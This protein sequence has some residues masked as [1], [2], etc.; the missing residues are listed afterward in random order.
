MFTP[1]CPEIRKTRN[2]FQLKLEVSLH[3]VKQTEANFPPRAICLRTSLE[4]GE[5]VRLVVPGG[6]RFYQVKLSTLHC[7]TSP[8]GNVQTAKVYLLPSNGVR[9]SNVLVLSVCLSFCSQGM[10]VP[11]Q[12]PSPMQTCSNV[13]NLDLTVQ[14]HPEMFQFVELGPLYSPSQHS[15]LF[16]T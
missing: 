7:T 8:H 14:G 6:Y 3:A 1:N 10:G 11:K 2:S 13:F 5:S 16:N 12:G 4:R 9:Q 15:K